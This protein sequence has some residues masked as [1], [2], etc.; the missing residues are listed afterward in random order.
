MIRKEKED[1]SVALENLEKAALLLQPQISDL[2]ETKTYPFLHKHDDQST[3]IAIY[4]N[5]GLI[6]DKNNRFDQACKYYEQALQVKNESKAEI[7][8]V[9]DNENFDRADKRCGHVM[10][11]NK[12]NKMQKTTTDELF[13]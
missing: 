3:L 10:N 7:A 13:E 4:N 8:T 5:I 12:N 6:H 11:K 1:S 2:V 9:R